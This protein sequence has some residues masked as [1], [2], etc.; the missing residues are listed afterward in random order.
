MHPTER[1]FAVGDQFDTMQNLRRACKEYAVQQNF[2]F[3]TSHSD[4]KRYRIHCVSS[5][6]CPWRLHAA[7]V[8]VECS[9]DAKTVEIKAIGDEHTCNGV[10]TLHHRQAGSS[11]ISS[12][13][14]GRVQDH[15][16]Y[17]PV[18]VI[19]DA[20]RE[21]GIKVSYSTAWRAKED[22]LAKINGSHEDAYAQLP[23]YCTDLV[24]SNPG[25]TVVIERTDDNRFLRLFICYAASASGFAHC[26]PILGLDGAH[27][28]GKYL[29]ILLS[30][31]ATDANGSL[32]P[33]AHAIVDVENDNNWLWFAT[34]LHDVIQMHAPAFLVPRGLAFVSDRQK[35]LLEAIELLFP[36]SPH[37][38][39]LRHLYENMHKKYKNP[40]L[41]ERLY[42]TARAV[43]EHEYNVAI[44]R[45]RDVDADAVE[46]LESHAPKEHWCEYYFVGNRYGH[47]TSN[48]AESI[49]AWLLDARE[50]PILAMLEQIRHQLMDWFATRHLC[51]MNVEG[52]LVSSVAVQIKNTLTTR[53]RRYRVISANDVVFEVFLTE[54]MSSYCVRLDACT[55]EC[56]EWQMS[57]I[58]C[59][60]VLAVSLELG[61]DPQM[62]AKPF[63]GLAAY[64]QTYANAIFPPNVNVGGPIPFVLQGDPHGVH[65]PAL[66]PPNVRRQAGRPRKARIRGGTEG[67]GREKRT[68]RCATCGNTGHS[69]RTCRMR[70]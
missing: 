44:Q 35:G 24:T 28:K 6:K 64:R 53:A 18:E 50:M 27:L 62:Y 47:I 9:G 3:K 43:T 34:I 20:R 5:E 56:A 17:R 39:C 49:N 66:L 7:L 48:I 52:I 8:P 11:L 14:Q 12:V 16:G 13:I 33:L 54:T 65:L 63:Y 4:K 45:M 69:R 46:W 60:H 40:Q 22:A 67:G 31:T 58:P 51:D 25:S 59:G 10:R 23:Q 15:P 26:R 70:G 37:G 1:C 55:C 41:R 2:E 29:G 21:Q 61:T 42:D 32:F 30:A 19:R 68:F 57:G 38:Y 36:D